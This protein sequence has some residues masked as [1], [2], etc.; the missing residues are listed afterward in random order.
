M[1]LNYSETAIGNMALAEVGDE[2]ISSIDAQD[3]TSVLVKETYLIKRDV[4]MASHPW[5]FA[6][7]SAVLAENATA[8]AFGFDNRFEIPADMLRAWAKDDSKDPWIREGNFLLTD[9]EVFNLRYISNVTDTTKFSPGFIIL[10]S[11]LIAHTLTYKLNNKASLRKEI[12]STINISSGRILLNECQEGK[13][14]LTP[15][16]SDYSWLGGK[17]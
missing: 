17:S 16:N 10:L 6:M 12:Q 11:L 15:D 5:N 14:D 2:R 13:P 1:A 8:P 9:A 4:L 7:A 3:S